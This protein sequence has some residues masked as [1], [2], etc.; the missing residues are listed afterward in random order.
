MAC[1]GC[2]L[3]KPGWGGLRAV[4]RQALQPELF[5]VPPAAQSLDSLH[6]VCKIRQACGAGVSA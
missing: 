5:T 3:I 2:L 4:L 6:A 1:G